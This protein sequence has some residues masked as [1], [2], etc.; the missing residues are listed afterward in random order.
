[1]ARS[2]KGGAEHCF[3]QQ[4]L[5]LRS[6][7]RC[8]VADATDPAERLAITNHRRGRNQ[9]WEAVPI[10]ALKFDLDAV[11]GQVALDGGDQVPLNIRDLIAGPVAEWRI[12][13]LKF[14]ARPAHHV[15]QP[16]ID[17]GLAA[18]HID[19]RNAYVEGLF[20]IGRAHV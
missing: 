20:E 11:G 5:L 4:A 13:S 12:L 15:A 3:A 14:C 6:S 16:F 7:S 19:H 9:S 1:M 10:A 17:V 8:Q 18:I 2:I